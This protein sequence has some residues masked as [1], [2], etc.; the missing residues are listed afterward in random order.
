M[1]QSHAISS[2]KL[3]QTWKQTERCRLLSSDIN[4]YQSHVNCSFTRRVL[5]SS[6]FRFSKQLNCG[7]LR[8]I[9]VSDGAAIYDLAKSQI[10]LAYEQSDRK[11]VK[12]SRKHHKFPR[13]NVSIQLLHIM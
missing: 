10:G 12:F 9:V 3:M 5:Q 11:A 1:I 4:C 13:Q 7:Y 8:D 2:L 6:L